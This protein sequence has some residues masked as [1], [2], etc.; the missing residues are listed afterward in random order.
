VEKGSP[1]GLGL[2]VEGFVQKGD[3]AEAQKFFE[4]GIGNDGRPARGHGGIDLRF[5]GRLDY[6][7]KSRAF[8]RFD[9]VALGDCW[10]WTSAYHRGNSTFGRYPIGIAFELNRGECP[11]DRIHPKYAPS[12]AGGAAYFQR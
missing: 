5:I 3:F 2:R 4:K 6:D 10:G 12:Y 8:D 9:L 1:A 11:A 7:P